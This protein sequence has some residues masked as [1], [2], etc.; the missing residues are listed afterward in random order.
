MIM[1]RTSNPN[2]NQ[3]RGESSAKL[4]STHLGCASLFTQ[5]A[6]PVSSF[7]MGARLV[8]DHKRAVSL[9][10]L[11]A[12]KC[13]GEVDVGTYHMSLSSEYFSMSGLILISRW[14]RLL[15]T[16]LI[17]VLCIVVLCLNIL[18]E[19]YAYFTMS[20]LMSTIL[21]HV[22]KMLPEFY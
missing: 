22:N 21:Y 12:D 8:T 4:A 14:T 9:G 17:S 13:P 1:I 18:H 7:I 3:R 19:Y 11:T 2:P 6:T 5:H 20:I 16:L 10:L 15:V